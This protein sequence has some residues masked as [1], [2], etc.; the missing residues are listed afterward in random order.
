MAQIFKSQ[1]FRN[2]A[3]N[4][5][6]VAFQFTVSGTAQ[7]GVSYVNMSVAEG[8]DLMALAK[9]AGLKVCKRAAADQATLTAIVNPTR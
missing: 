2:L 6:R 4:R 9:K 5:D 1:S 7:S 3:T 8:D